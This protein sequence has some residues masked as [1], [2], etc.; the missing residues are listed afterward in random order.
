MATAHFIVS[1]VEGAMIAV[2]G[3]VIAPR[4]ANRCKVGV[5]GEKCK[6]CEQ[7]AKNA[8]VTIK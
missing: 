8:W 7:R 3:E 6:E 4:D 2:C 5:Y 1:G